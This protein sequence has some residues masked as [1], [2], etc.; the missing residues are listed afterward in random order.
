MKDNGDE[1]TFSITRHYYEMTVLK[2]KLKEKKKIMYWKYVFSD[3]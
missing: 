3:I 2:I 1:I